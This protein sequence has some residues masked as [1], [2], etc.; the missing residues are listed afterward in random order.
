MPTAQAN[1]LASDWFALRAVWADVPEADRA[2][3][4]AYFLLPEA[5]LMSFTREQ[6][7]AAYESWS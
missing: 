3:A 2:A 5:D 6:L 7:V 1:L 4:L